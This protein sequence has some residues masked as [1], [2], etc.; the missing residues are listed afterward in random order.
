MPAIEKRTLSQLK[1]TQRSIYIS[2]KNSCR[3]IEVFS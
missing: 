3:R 1:D 2:R